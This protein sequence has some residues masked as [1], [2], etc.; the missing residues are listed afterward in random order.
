MVNLNSHIVLVDQL[1]KN[2]EIKKFKE[3][4]DLWYIYQNDLHK[5]GFQNGMAYG[6]LKTYIEETLLIK[7]YMIKHLKLPKIQNMMDIKESFGSMVHI[8]LIF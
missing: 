8:F 7:Y 3:T 6:I 2:K 4:R 1:Q 5:A